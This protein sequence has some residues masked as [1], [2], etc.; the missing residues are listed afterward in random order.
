MKRKFKVVSI[1]LAVA[2][3][4]LI[5]VAVYYPKANRIKV[6]PIPSS[7]GTWIRASPIEKPDSYVVVLENVDKWTKAAFENPGKWVYVDNQ[8]TKCWVSSL[9]TIW[10]VSWNEKYYHM[11]LIFMY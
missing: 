1:I 5:F 4:V 11:D 9:T 3:V 6:E 2:A 7:S 10:D 8:T